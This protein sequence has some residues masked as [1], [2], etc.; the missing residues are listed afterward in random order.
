[1]ATRELF[2]FTCHVTNH[3]PDQDSPHADRT[4]KEIA[5]FITPHGFGHATRA[6][7]VL[8][9]LSG[10]SAEVH[11][12]LLTTVPETLFSE[13]LHN[14]TCHRVPVDVGL[15]Q[16][17]ALGA[18]I[19]GTIQALDDFLPYRESLLEELLQR[20]GRC[21][22]VVCDIAPVGIVVAQR[23]GVPA[24][25]VENF[26]WDWIYDYYCDRHGDMVRHA[27][28]MQDLFARADFRIQ[29]EPLCS[30][31][32][33]DLR[34]GPISRK[35]R[36][37][38]REIR[39]NLNPARNRPIVFVTM[40]GVAQGL[41]NLEKLQGHREY[42]FVFSGREQ[43][44]R[45]GDNIIL[46]SRDSRMYHPDLIAAADVV[47]CKA[48]YSTIA[49][50]YQ[51]GAR[52]ISVGRDD[53]PETAPL[54]RFLGQ[55]LDAVTVGPS[56]YDNGEWLSLLPELLSRPGRDRAPVNGADAVADFLYRLM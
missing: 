36:G 13:S 37:T 53:F 27:R 43:G 50:C 11:A 26:T 9:A 6:A 1:M 23:L 29:T 56:G 10:R 21:S 14:F 2:R 52:V 32:D 42:T 38:E 22:L 54:E 47:I 19:P 51:A 44:G 55:H 49:E 41:P 4:V 34:C 3:R 15:V 40:G 39:D 46:L 8:E 7:A 35:T 17:S 18:D 5:Y 16:S 12:Q 20:C 24:V 31:V 48:G 25:V 45:V 33:C 30:G 28:Y